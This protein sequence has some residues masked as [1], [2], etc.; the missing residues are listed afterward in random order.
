VLHDDR[1]DKVIARACELADEELLGIDDAAR[2]IAALCDGDIA[3]ID[4]ARRAVADR[5]A[6]VPDRR[7]KQAASLIR[8]ALEIGDWD[9]RGYEERHRP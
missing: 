1:V 3:V 5:V 2:D 4:A 7:N 6:R 9:W 8:R